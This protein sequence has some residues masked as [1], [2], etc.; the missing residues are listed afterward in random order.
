MNEVCS[1]LFGLK[2]MRDTT[3]IT[4]ETYIAEV[5]KL[6]QEYGTCVIAE[7]MVCLGLT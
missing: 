3:L 6:C 2:A 5:D 4:E 7:T 1:I